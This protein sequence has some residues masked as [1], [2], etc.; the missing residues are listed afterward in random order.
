MEKKGKGIF[1]SA[2]QYLP[3]EEE[4]EKDAFQYLQ[5]YLD[6]IKKNKSKVEDFKD[7]VNELFYKIQ[8]DK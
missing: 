1:A 6:I 8:K 2:K 5:S 3:T 4:S 7:L